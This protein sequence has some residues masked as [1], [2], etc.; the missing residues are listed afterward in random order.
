MSA[1][2]RTQSLSYVIFADGQRVRQPVIAMGID[3]YIIRTGPTTVMKIPKLTETLHPDDSVEADEDNDW[4]VQKTAI[5]EKFYQRLEGIPGIARCLGVSVNGIALEYYGNGDLE[6]YI[7]NHPPAPWSRRLDWITQIIETLSQ[8]HARKVLVF[9]IALRNL[10]LADDMSVRLID[11]AN[12]SLLPED[13]EYLVDELETTDKVDMLHAAN[14]IYSIVQW[15]KF[16]LDCVTEAE[17]PSLQSLPPVHAIQLGDVISKMWKK[18]YT[19]I[20]DV[21]RDLALHQSQGR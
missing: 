13:Q 12:G 3:G 15:E 19:S 4:T 17:W 21:R 7:R 14:V 2:I 20:L 8:I 5:E 1:S 9:D 10:L 6:D 16:Q 18:Q 11:F